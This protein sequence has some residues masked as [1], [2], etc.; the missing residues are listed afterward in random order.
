M[1]PVKTESIAANAASRIAS[2]GHGPSPVAADL[3]G[4]KGLGVE[5]GRG[6]VGVRFGAGVGRVEWGRGGVGRGWV[7]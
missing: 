4:V 3:R 2:A 1:S 7:G 5:W 6:G